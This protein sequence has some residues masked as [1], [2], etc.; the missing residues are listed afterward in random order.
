MSLSLSILEVAVIGVG[1]AILLVDLWTPAAQ[2][3][4]L[5][6]AAAAAV[7]IIFLGSL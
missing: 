5:G 1:L 2:K 4:N 7:G 6:Y 3:R